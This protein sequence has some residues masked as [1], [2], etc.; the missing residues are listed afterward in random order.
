MSVV[1]LLLQQPDLK[2][3]HD[4]LASSRLQVFLVA[5]ASV[6]IFSRQSFMTDSSLEWAVCLAK[7][8]DIWC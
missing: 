1:A 4:S 2:F 6:C 8:G 3:C 5:I 7:E